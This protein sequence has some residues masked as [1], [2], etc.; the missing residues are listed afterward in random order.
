MTTADQQHQRLMELIEEVSV[1]FANQINDLKALLSEREL[2]IQE[3]K[4]KPTVAAFP[5]ALSWDEALVQ[6]L[7]KEEYDYSDWRDMYD[8]CDPD[9][10]Y[11]LVMEAAELYMLSNREAK[12]SL[13]KDKLPEQMQYVLVAASGGRRMAAFFKSNEFLCYNLLTEESEE[14]EE[15]IAWMP[16]PEFKP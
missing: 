11:K 4:A 13:I 8:S 2:E 1:N 9:I 12:W 3:L 10:A 14:I 15:A 6:I 7:H 16:L 5:K